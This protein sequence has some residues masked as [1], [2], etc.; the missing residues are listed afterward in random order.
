M[1]AQAESVLFVQFVSG[2]HLLPVKQFKSGKM[3][4]FVKREIRVM[5]QTSK[6]CRVTHYKSRLNFPYNSHYSHK[7]TCSITEKG[8]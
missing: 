2:K 7:F 4:V 1:I 8:V 3:T 5:R 6:A